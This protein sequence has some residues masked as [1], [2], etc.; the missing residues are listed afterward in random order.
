MRSVRYLLALSAVTATSAMGHAQGVLVAPHGIF[1]DHRVRTGSFELYNP[2]PQSVEVSVSTLFGYPV[3]DSLGRLSL[4]TTASPDST[5]PSA[6]AWIEAY[7]R[8]LMLRPLERQRV[9]LLARP[10]AGLPDGEYWTRL[11]VAA[12]GGRLSVA[13]VPDTSGI[14]IGLT[15]EMR[16]VVAVFY[17]KGA[18][19][20]G[21]VLSDVRGDILGDSLVVRA[22]LTRQGN[23]AFIG[24]VR[25]R[26]VDD[27]GRQVAAF[28]SQLGVYYAMEPRFTTPVG[29]LRTARYT[30]RLDVASERDDLARE[31]LLHASTV[32][33]SALV[34][35]ARRSP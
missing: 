6:A 22:R 8:R 7:P 12:K 15:L 25:G 23:A 35:V 10:P 26:L 28:T 16:T 4:R 32:R 9:R 2:N 3:T 19:R 29:P 31:S 21:I 24:T 5:E 20:T 13:G 27:A 18:V 17:R 34:T 33:D 14:Q 11:V 30:L 1:I